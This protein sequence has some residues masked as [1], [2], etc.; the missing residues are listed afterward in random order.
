MLLL[1]V[2]TPGHIAD[3]VIVVLNDDSLARM[4]EADPA[5]VIL[6]QTG[7]SLVNPTILIC[8]EKQSPE[9]TRLLNGG[10]VKAIIAHLQ[11]GWQFRPD[12]GDHDRGPEPL[13][14]SN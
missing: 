7:R 14:R 9:L 5:E 10:D 12:R 6:R 4:A 8:H 1:P 11:R 2:E 3:A 13:H